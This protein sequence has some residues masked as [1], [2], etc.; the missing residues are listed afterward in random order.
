M[1]LHPRAIPPADLIRESVSAFEES[2]RRREIELSAEVGEDLPLAHVDPDRLSRVL[3]NLIGNALKCTPPGGHVKVAVGLS[4]DGELVFSVSDTGPGIRAEDRERLF[5]PFWK[6]GGGG[7][8]LGL[9][10]AET[11]VKGGLSIGR[12]SAWSGKHVPIHRAA[13]GREYSI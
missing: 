9:S 7:V 13:G 11:L 1:E 10:I 8:G 4:D 2:A 3:F 6:G 12:E 5:E